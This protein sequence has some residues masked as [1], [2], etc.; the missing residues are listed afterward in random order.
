MARGACHVI[1]PDIARRV[2]IVKKLTETYKSEPLAREDRPIV[3]YIFSV[4]TSTRVLKPVM[5]SGVSSSGCPGKSELNLKA[6]SGAPV[7]SYG[8]K[9]VTSAARWDSGKERD[10]TWDLTRT[11][12]VVPAQSTPPQVQ[13]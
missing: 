4:R 3:P 13:M 6:C 1:D 9:V 12:L 7:R 8:P 10:A 5:D 11:S 2:A